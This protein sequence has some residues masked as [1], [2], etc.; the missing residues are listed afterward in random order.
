MQEQMFFTSKQGQAEV[1]FVIEQK[2]Q[3]SVRFARHIIFERN[4]VFQTDFLQLK[5]LAKL[6]GFIPT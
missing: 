2:K 3:L 6:T 1:L 4:N 5:R